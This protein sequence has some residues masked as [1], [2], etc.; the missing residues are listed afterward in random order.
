MKTRKQPRQPV[1]AA[2]TCS[3]KGGVPWVV[4]LDDL[5]VG[6]CRIVD[7]IGRLAKGQQVEIRIDGSGVFR[8]DV[9]WHRNGEAG[10]AFVRELPHAMLKRLRDR[11]STFGGHMSQSIGA[12]Y[13]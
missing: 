13:C 6:G 10:L 7:P 2:G 9:C 11:A 12:R 3:H 1:S 8:A 5:T 4:R